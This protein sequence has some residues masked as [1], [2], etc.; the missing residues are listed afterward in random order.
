MKYACK[1]QGWS[2]YALLLCVLTSFVQPAFAWTSKDGS[3]E[4]NGFIENAS[5]NRARV[6]LSKSRNTG[7]LEFSKKF[8][9]GV[10]LHGTFR[11]TFDGVYKL[12]SDNFGDESGGSVRLQS[13]NGAGFVDWGAAPVP[14]GG[15][16]SLAT[17]PNEG[18][19]IVGGTLHGQRGGLI[20][21]TPTR[22]CDVDSRGCIDG[23]L[24]F[25]ED[26]LAS[27]EFNDRLDFIR[28]LYLD[29][30]I[31]LSNGDELNLRLGR[32]QIV[33]G[34]TDLFRVLDVINPVDF[35]RNNIYDELE[36]IRYPLA[37]VN[38]EY[39]MGATDTFDDLNFQLV[40]IAEKFR[41]SNLGQGGSPNSILDAGSLFRSLNNCWDNGCTL[42]NFLQPAGGLATDFAPGIAGIRTAHLPGWSLDNTQ[43]GGRVEGVY[44]SVGFSL[45]AFYTRS[46]LPSLRGGIPALNPF[47]GVTGPVPFLPAFDIHFPRVM[48]IGGSTDFYVDAIKSAFRVELAHTS[49]EEFADGLSTRLFSKSDVIR[50]VVGVDRPTYIPWLNKHRTFLISAQVFGQ[51]ILDHRSTQSA[52]GQVG[53]ADWKD[54]WTGTLLI[55]GFYKNDQVQPRVILAHDVRAQATAIGPQVDW[56]INDN[57]RLTVGGNFKVGSGGR[58]VDDNRTADPFFGGTASA[59]LASFNPL[60]RFRSG[61]IGMAQKEDEVQ[62]TLRYRF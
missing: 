38:A 43:L 48:L 35:S 45:N 28:E 34:R 55:Q 59:G 32:Q 17:N 40:W 19:A 1:Y 7:Q 62:L 39:R 21:A 61:P 30:P 57:W 15:G 52:L 29:V 50:Y 5:F 60:G 41:P 25:D 23:Y 22:P 33:W 4:A 26:E 36:D 11:G 37:A 47:T 42:G 9:K 51:H 2:G 12:N 31:N 49:G 54:N 6:G 56:F 16:F 13:G 8:H 14:L 18:L 58:K 46:H 53:F 27:P 20:F 24:D 3:L 44:K 10:S